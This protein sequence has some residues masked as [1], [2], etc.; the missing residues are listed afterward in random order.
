MKLLVTAQQ[1]LKRKWTGPID[2]LKWVNHRNNNEHT[3]DIAL[4]QQV[5]F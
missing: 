1:S 3:Y 2:R 5:I 4:F